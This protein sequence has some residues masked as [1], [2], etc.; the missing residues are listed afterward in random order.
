VKDEIVH[1]KSSLKLDFT[2]FRTKL[3]FTRVLFP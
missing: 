3:Q 1:E 2:Y